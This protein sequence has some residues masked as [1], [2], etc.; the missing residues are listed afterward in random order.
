MYTAVPRG[1]L[2]QGDIFADVPIREISGDDD[3]EWSGRVIVLSHS[4]E[5]E[6]KHCTAPLVAAIK[7]EAE[8]SPDWWGHAKGDRLVN[9]MYLPPGESIA[10]GLV[11]FRLIHRV[12]KEV[13][14]QAQKIASLTEEAQEALTYYLTRFFARRELPAA[15]EAAEETGS[16]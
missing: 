15:E 7:E 4:C 12:R 16:S 5:I 6:K 11:D 8:V 1:E 13:L 9:A 14:A 3:R 10:A 2:K